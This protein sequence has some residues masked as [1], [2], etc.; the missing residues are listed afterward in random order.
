MP[1]DILCLPLPSIFRAISILV[2][3][4]FL[5]TV[6]CRIHYLHS[7]FLYGGFSLT[8]LFIHLLKILDNTV[9]KISVCCGSPTEIRT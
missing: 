9:A 4:V 1:V 3:E 7:P 2:S 6:A 5:F 8:Q